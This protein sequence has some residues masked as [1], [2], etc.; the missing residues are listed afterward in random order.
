MSA[1]L[2]PSSRYKELRGDAEV[3]AKIEAK[4]NTAVGTHRPICVTEIL[5]VLDP[6]PSGVHVD[7]TLGFGGHA[8]AFLQRVVPGGVVI[9]LDADSDELKRTH[10]RLQPMYG[11]AI[12]CVHSNYAALASVVLDRVPGGADSVLADLGCSSMQLDGERGFSFKRDQPL[13]MRL[14]TT[15]GAPAYERFDGWRADALEAILRDNADEP[16]SAELAAALV[17]AHARSPLRTTLQLA[18]AVRE[19]LPRSLSEEEGVDTCRRVFQ[20]VRIAVNDEFSKLDALLFS[21]PLVLR[22]GARAA[23]L[24]FHSGE[25]RRVKKSF[26]LNAAAGVYSYVSDVI[27]PSWEEQRAN[28]R[29]RCAKLR[30]VQRA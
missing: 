14:D 17:A 24:T 9:G 13:D 4:G 5:G 28:S 8:Q 22:P 6:K 25:D 16:R 3:V 1:G 19:A 30:W 7:A 18:R 12:Q 11:D 10:A 27:R 29:S 21:L 2:P 23:V 20:A 15:R 26:K